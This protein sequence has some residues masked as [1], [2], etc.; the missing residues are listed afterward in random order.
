M[1]S[2]D[3]SASSAAVDLM[4]QQDAV[5]E[6]VGYNRKAHGCSPVSTQPL[7]LT[8]E[9][10]TIFLSAPVDEVIAMVEISP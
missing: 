9:L 10:L 6:D 5:T 7:E 8:A 3:L 4:Q 2:P 1:L